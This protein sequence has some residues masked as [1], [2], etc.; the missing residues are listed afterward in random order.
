MKPVCVVMVGYPASGKSTR[1]QSLAAMEPDAFV[2]STDNLIEEW[3]AAMGWSY[4]FA[5]DKYIDKAT[6][7]MNE[8][9]DVAIRDK[10]TIIW[11]QTNLGVGK[12]R[13]VINRMKQAGYRVE[14]ECIEPPATDD[15]YAEWQKRLAGRPGKTIPIDIINRMMDTYVKPE[16]DEGFDVVAIFDLYGNCKEL[17]NAMV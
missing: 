16:I 12:R 1:V 11:D 9:L 10:L 13:K 3:G 15:D 14:C 2:Y 6:K 4:D 8:W 7:Q 5:F 17:K